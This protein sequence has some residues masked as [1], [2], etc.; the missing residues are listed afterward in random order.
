MNSM[1]PLAGL[2]AQPKVSR[3]DIEG[4]YN[5]S[6]LEHSSV[7]SNKASQGTAELNDHVQI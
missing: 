1:S 4:R 5:I 3:N 2:R 6:P 7:E